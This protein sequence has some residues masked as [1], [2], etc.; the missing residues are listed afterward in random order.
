MQRRFEYYVMWFDCIQHQFLLF[1][2]IDANQFFVKCDWQYVLSAQFCH[3]IPVILRN[4]LFDAVYVV[5]CEFLEF[6]LDYVHVQSKPSVGINT[7]FQCVFGKSAADFGEQ[8]HFVLPLD[9]SDLEL[10]AS[11]T[12]QNLLLCLCQHLVVV[13]HPYQSIRRYAYL[14]PCKRSIIEYGI[15]LVIVQSRFEGKKQCRIW[16][17]VIVIACTVQGFVYKLGY[18][19]HPGVGIAVAGQI[20]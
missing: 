11:V 10:D 13:A 1:G 7:Y 20:G 6:V 17:E 4:G 18:I 9:C 19:A 16:P 15:L 8:A 14:A 12:C 5:S 3:F 2:V